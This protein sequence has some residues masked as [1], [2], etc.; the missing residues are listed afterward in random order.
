[1]IERSGWEPK[2]ATY[3][4]LL[5][6]KIISLATA[7]VVLMA[8]PREMGWSQILMPFMFQTLRYPSSSPKIILAPAIVTEL[9]TFAFSES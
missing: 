7:G 1:M 2:P 8:A 4:K 9:Q 5:A 3:P 6:A